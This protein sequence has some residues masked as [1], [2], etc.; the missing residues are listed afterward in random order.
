MWKGKIRS[1]DEGWCKRLEDKQPK[2][3]V[4]QL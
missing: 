4:T 3:D 2:I 1:L